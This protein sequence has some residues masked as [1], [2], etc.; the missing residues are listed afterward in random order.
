MENNKRNTR[1]ED[2][3]LRNKT[4]CILIESGRTSIY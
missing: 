2:L 1:I 4:K 3:K